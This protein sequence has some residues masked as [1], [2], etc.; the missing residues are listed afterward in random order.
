[1]GGWAPATPD[2]DTVRA[3]ASGARA[4][5]G[6]NVGSNRI[7][8]MARGWSTDAPPG[9]G[10]PTPP[11][12]IPGPEAVALANI[13]GSSGLTSLNLGPTGRSP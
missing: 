6:K 3:C 12:I 1:M 11:G 7:G 13:I 10:I 2:A 4:R 5:N 8:A 9:F